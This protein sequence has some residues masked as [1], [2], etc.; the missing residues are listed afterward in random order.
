M[1]WP[2]P[3]VNGGWRRYRSDLENRTT[4]TVLCLLLNIS[5]KMPYDLCCFHISVLNWECASLLWSPATIV[6]ADAAVREAPN[7]DCLRNHPPTKTEPCSRTL[8]DM[9]DYQVISGCCQPRRRCTGKSQENAYYQ[10]LIITEHM[11]SHDDERLNRGLL[12]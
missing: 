3:L 2:Q 5:Q 12:L 10:P 1:I 6:V 8:S 9:I 4:R 7:E 11:T